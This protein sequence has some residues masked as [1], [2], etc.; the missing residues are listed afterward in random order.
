MQADPI[1]EGHSSRTAALS[2]CMFI[3]LW[4]TDTVRD[5]AG[6]VSVSPGAPGDLSPAPTGLAGH[7]QCQ[8]SC[9]HH[10]SSACSSTHLLVLGG[11]VFHTALRVA[12]SWEPRPL[13]QRCHSREYCPSTLTVRTRGKNSPPSRF[14]SPLRHTDC[15]RRLHVRTTGACTLAGLPERSTP[16]SRTAKA[17][18]SLI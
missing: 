15:A 2:T 10:F 9:Q 14:P 11:S 17:S 12:N 13:Q 6:G 5:L 18:K 7:C 1:T 3:S 8:G 4:L 16:I